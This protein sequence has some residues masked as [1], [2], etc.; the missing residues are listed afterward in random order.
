[1]V[2]K[3]ILGVFSG[4]VLVIGGLVVGSALFPLRPA[5][6]DPVPAEV[7][8]AVPE[9]EP[10]A[11]ATPEPEPVAEP[12]VA[13]APAADA[14]P[15]EAPA[16]DP[17]PAPQPDLAAEAT[18]PEA[19]DTSAAKVADQSEPTSEGATEAVTTVQES[20]AAESVAEATPDA[21]PSP[22]SDPAP[23][24]EVAPEPAPPE[25]AADPVADPPAVAEVAAPE[26]PLQPVLLP[27]LDADGVLEA[28]DKVAIAPQP[29][30]AAEETA[31]DVEMAEAETEEPPAAE[32]AEADPAPASPEPAPE[33]EVLPEP[34]IANLPEPAPE[35]EP[36]QSPTFIPAPSLAEKAEGVVVDRL[37]RIGDEVATAEADP[38]LE[39]PAEDRPPI[40][41]FAAPFDNPDAKPVMAIVLI[42]TGAEDLDRAGLAALPFPVSFALDPLDPATPARARTYRDGG[43]EVVML[44]TGL[45]DGAQASDVEVSFQSMAQGLPQAVAVMDL[46]GGAFQ[47]R[48]TL[49]SIVVPVIGSQGR[50]LLTWDQGLNAADQ[51]ARRE[52]IA[53]AVIF[54]DLASSGTDKGSVRRILERA[55]F[56]AGQDGRVAVAAQATPEMVAVLLEWSVEGR[57]ALIALAPLTA[58][59]QVD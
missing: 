59:L 5:A 41:A 16:E 6:T 55:V 37:P 26:Q 36:E 32:V 23:Q 8:A 57:A 51:V 50:G 31:P 21:E 52:D 40:A 4:G 35:A 33:A 7:S 13:P 39:A 20:P 30:L 15:A 9:P 27:Q 34:E 46:P 53:S 44:A 2:G 24:P 17:A 56:K 12:V 45:A 43:K 47:S 25:V 18:A 1:V 11:T 3:F 54:R 28:L 58:V 48:R 29:P 10:A 42:D 22:A 49:A 14:E 19:E 38:A